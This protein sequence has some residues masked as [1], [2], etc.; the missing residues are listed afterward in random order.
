MSLEESGALR[1]RLLV[2]SLQNLP[3]NADCGTIIFL[4]WAFLPLF[5]PI[6]LEWI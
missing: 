5:R 2:S 3:E 6:P 4:P 1:T